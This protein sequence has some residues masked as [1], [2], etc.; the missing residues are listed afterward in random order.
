MTVD[1]DEIMLNLRRRAYR[2]IGSGSGRNVYDIG[3]GY[4]AKVARNR[5][6]L[7]QNEA[8]YEISVADESG[9]FA[10]IIDATPNLRITIM[11]KAVP[12][13]SFSTVWRYFGVRSNR[14]LYNI[15]LIQSTM[16]R[17]SLIFPDLCRAQ[18]WGVV[19]GRP[20]IIDY[21]FTTSVNRRY[22]FR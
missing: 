15:P 18:N 20:V 7:A 1:F 3:D 10:N 11:E 21:G 5:K 19:N 4:V 6:G 9:L 2:Q 22:Y 17:H 12:L 14:Q 16:A 8:E 13:H